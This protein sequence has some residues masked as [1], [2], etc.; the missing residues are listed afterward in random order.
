MSPQEW[1]LFLSGGQ[2]PGFV[3]WRALGDFFGSSQIDIL[4]VETNAI[5]ET[6][7]NEG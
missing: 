2:K 7:T 3:L 4:S 6:E 5:T 1:G